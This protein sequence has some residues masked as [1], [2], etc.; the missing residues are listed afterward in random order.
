VIRGCHAKLT[1]SYQPLEAD[2]LALKANT[3][4]AVANCSMRIEPLCRSRTW[5]SYRSSGAARE[6]WQTSAE[7]QPAWCHLPAASQRELKS[8]LAVTE[9]AITPFSRYG[10]VCSCYPLRC[11]TTVKGDEFA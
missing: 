4:V 2:L 6:K 3:N 7:G 10:T 11:Q 9:R 1:K 8:P 5:T